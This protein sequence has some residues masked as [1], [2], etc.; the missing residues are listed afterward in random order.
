MDEQEYNDLDRTQEMDSIEQ[1]SAAAHGITPREEFT[2]LNSAD[3]DK[4]LRMDSI[5]DEEYS[6][7]YAEYD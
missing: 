5:A 4:T 7:D 3:M 6:D 1:G 2:E